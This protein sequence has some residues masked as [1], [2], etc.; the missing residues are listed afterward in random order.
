MRAELT[1][2]S[3]PGKEKKNHMSVLLVGKCPKWPNSWLENALF[4]V[5]PCA[6]SL[7]GR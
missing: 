6:E 4:I 3:I 2:S 1:R 5:K 7:P